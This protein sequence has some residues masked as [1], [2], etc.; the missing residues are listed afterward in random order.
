M[1]VLA[2]DTD[3]DGDPMTVSSPVLADPTQGTVVVN[4][5]GTLTFTPANNFAGT[6]VI[7]YTVSDGHGGTDTATV[8]VNVGNNT[9]PTGADSV[10]TVAE[11]N[12]YTV[13]ATDFGPPGRAPFGGPAG[14]RRPEL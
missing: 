4:P 9:P 6:A 14:R 2:N 12:A 8:T 7:T 5:N 3:A 13:L 1:A 11:D 10:H